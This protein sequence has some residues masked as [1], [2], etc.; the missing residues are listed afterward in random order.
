MSDVAPVSRYRIAEFGALLADPARVAI[1]LALMDGSARPAGELARHAHVAAATASAHLARLVEIGLLAVRPQGRHRY[2]RLADDGAAHLIETLVAARGVRSGP[3]LP[4]THNGNAALRNARTCYRHLAG[5]LG[6]ALFDA[7]LR[8]ELLIT[9]SDGLRLSAGGVGRL[10]T[11]ELLQ[12][13]DEPVMVRLQGR[14]CL[15]WTERRDHLGGR[16]GGS[17]CERLLTRGW[18][19]VCPS[20]RALTVTGLGRERLRNLGVG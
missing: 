1:L 16:L 19:R 14:A 8:H 4:P 17:L 15:D 9:T 12:S 2:F 11:L 20:S 10:R 18:L 3:S 13:D 5:R 7:L 6:V